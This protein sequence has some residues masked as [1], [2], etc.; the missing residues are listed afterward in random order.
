MVSLNNSII[1]VIDENDLVSKEVV[2][3]IRNRCPERFGWILQQVLVASHM[4]QSKSKY[5]LIVDSDTIIIKP[6][7]WVDKF[8]RQILMPTFE[9]HRPYYDFFIHISK[10]YKTPKISFVSHHMLVQTSIFR[11]IFQFFDNNILTALERAFEFANLED[12]SPFDLKYEIYAQ[13]LYY[14]YPQR[15]S[16]VKWANLSCTRSELSNIVQGKV[17]LDFYKSRYNSLSFHHWNE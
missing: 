8:E 10:K 2:S 6:Q 5:V 4:L 13:Y 3:L 12:N 14:N 1:S 9:L 11:E 17:N 15:I 7:V 16:F